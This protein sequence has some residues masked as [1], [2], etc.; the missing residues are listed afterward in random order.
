MCKLV[1]NVKLT[2]KIEILNKIVVHMCWHTIGIDVNGPMTE[3]T[4]A[5]K[6]II[7]AIDY[8]S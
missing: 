1:S 6:Y 3:K 8:F 2:K 7:A 5:N 4:N